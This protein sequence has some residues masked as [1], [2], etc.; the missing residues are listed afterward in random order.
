MRVPSLLLALA[1][2]ATP[3]TAA[4]Q[5]DGPIM[6]GSRIHVIGPFN[7]FWAVLESWRGDTLHVITAPGVVT[8]LPLAGITALRVVEPRSGARGA[9]VGAKWGAVIGAPLFA[10]DCWTDTDECREYW[11]MS[12]GLG[13]GRTVLK[14][15]LGGAVG[16]AAIGALIGAIFPG[17]REVDVPLRL[18]AAV[19]PGA[20]PALGVEF[21]H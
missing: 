12:P 15:A 5:H 17:S 21:R 4:A 9:L 7:S 18:R 2:L 14:A 6:P 11:E 13:N 3:A 8:P 20:A 1:L 16:S 19:A 10:L